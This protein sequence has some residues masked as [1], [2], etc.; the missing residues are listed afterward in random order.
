VRSKVLLRSSREVAQSCGV[1]FVNY[2]Y[3]VLLIIDQFFFITCATSNQT[4]LAGDTAAVRP[5]ATTA[6]T[7]AEAER[8]SVWQWPRCAIHSIRESFMHQVVN[9]VNL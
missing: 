7:A 2:L 3:L 1:S 5:L 6:A 9:E 8:S 4:V